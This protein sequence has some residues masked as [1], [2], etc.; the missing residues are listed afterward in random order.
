M[1][2]IILGEIEKKNVYFLKNMK[3][4]WS[5]DYFSFNIYLY[6]HKDFYKWCKIE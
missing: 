2:S 4:K 3:N 1:K 6:D 5:V